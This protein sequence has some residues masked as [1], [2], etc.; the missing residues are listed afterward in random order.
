MFAVNDD[1]GLAPVGFRISNIDDW[2]DLVKP[3][4]GPNEAGHKLRALKEFSYDDYATNE[5]GFS[6]LPGGLR[7]THGSFKLN[8][9][10]GYWWL[11]DHFGDDAVKTF[12]V[13]NFD[14]PL[15]DCAF[16]QCLS[17]Q[18][19]VVIRRYLIKESGLSVRCVRE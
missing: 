6:G 5:S 17:A 3:F 1:R 15:S 19:K 7:S 13:G 18:S 2:N 10:Y 14:I 16:F 8:R 11:I 4:W 12:Q 9:E